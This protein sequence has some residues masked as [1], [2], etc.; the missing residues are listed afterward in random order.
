MPP[1]ILSDVARRFRLLGEPVR[2]ELLNQLQVNG[3]MNV[4]RLVELT[5]HGQA[6]VSKHLRL[7]EEEGLLSRRQDGLYA[8]YRLE[9]PSLAALC[10]IVCGQLS[11][12]TALQD[13]QSGSG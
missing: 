3:E 7:M 10:M 11:V 4:Q 5:G 13:Y 12:Q 9:D 6:N 2:L 8:F 1:R